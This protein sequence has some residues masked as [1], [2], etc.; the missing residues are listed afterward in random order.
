MI[1][2]ASFDVADEK[3]H[4]ERISALEHRVS[5][6]EEKLEQRVSDL[7]ERLKGAATSAEEAEPDNWWVKSLEQK[8]R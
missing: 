4:H 5:E 1:S 7:E 2:C 3:S 8:R 6:L